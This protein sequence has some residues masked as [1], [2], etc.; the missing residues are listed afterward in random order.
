MNQCMAACPTT[1]I[2]A[3]KSCTH[4]CSTRCAPNTLLGAKRTKSEPWA[5]CNVD[6]GCVN[7]WE[8]TRRNEAAASQCTPVHPLTEAFMKTKPTPA[9]IDEFMNK[10]ATRFPAAGLAA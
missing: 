3:F 7:G 1:P 8:C 9:M 10:G 2:S 4:I 5:H 6:Q